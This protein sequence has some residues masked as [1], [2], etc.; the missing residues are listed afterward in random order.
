MAYE[1]GGMFS[2][3]RNDLY[4]GIHESADRLDVS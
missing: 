3:S 2:H 1:T 4:K